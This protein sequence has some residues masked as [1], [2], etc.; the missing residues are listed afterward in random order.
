MDDGGAIHLRED[1]ESRK[2]KKGSGKV[3]HILCLKQWDSREKRWHCDSER[4]HYQKSCPI[5]S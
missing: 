4:C 5:C 2:A 3:A 1:K